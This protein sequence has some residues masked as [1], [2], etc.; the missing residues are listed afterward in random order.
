MRDVTSHAI[1][2]IKS[3]VLFYDVGKR[4]ILFTEVKIILYI[5]SLPMLFIMYE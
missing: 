1:V 3:Q 5:T 4:F 2:D